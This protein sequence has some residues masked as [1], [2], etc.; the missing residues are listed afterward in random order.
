MTNAKNLMG[1]KPILPLLVSM[2]VPSILSMLIQSLYNVVDSIFVAWLSNDAL[3]AVSLAYPL[4]NLV[5]A[6]AVGFG[7]GINAYIARNLGKGTSTGW[8]KPLPWGSSL[9]LSM[10]LFSY[11]LGFSAVSHF[12]ICLP[13]IQRSCR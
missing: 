11:W 7:V 4:Q 9:P 5:L 13:M 3:T 2:S 8:I 10:L 12:Y 6:V 1:T